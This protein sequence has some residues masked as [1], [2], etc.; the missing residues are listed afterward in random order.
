MP[1]LLEFAHPNYGK[2]DSISS[3][4]RSLALTT[5]LSSASKYN[6]VLSDGIQ[7]VNL[8]DNSNVAR[9]VPAKRE[10]FDTS[11]T[12]ISNTVDDSASCDVARRHW[13]TCPRCRR[14]E[15]FMVVLEMIAYVLMGV[16]VI[17]AMNKK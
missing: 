12:T 15:F 4:N 17:V 10:A 14:R 5:S 8:D 7:P 3:T 6:N 1:A 9:F 11:Q 13:H 16:L 2:S